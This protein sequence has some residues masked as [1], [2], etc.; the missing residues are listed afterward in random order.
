M[1]TPITHL[2][3]TDKIFNRYFSDKDKAKFFVGTSFPDIRYLARIDRTIT[4]LP[5]PTMAEMIASPD[6]E[7]G[8][9]FHTYLDNVREGLVVRKNLYSFLPTSQFI[10]HAMKFVEDT[11]LYSKISNWKPIIRYFDKLYPEEFSYG[12]SEATVTKWHAGLQNYFGQKPG[13]KSITEYFN[14]F[15]FSDEVLTEI[16]KISLEINQN[17]KFTEYVEVLYN[18]FED[19]T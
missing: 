7:S 19:L 16:L 2:V 12:V 5:H 1:A 14:I 3:L 6:F 13:D 9:K 18:T 11:I 10:S 17:T 4:H 15:G 8:L